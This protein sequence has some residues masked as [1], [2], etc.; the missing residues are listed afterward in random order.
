[1]KKKIVI[2]I[3]V[4]II[5]ALALMIGLK[6]EAQKPYSKPNIVSD[7]PDKKVE[8]PKTED[9]KEDKKEEEKKEE[10]PK[11]E[12][13]LP[14]KASI[15]D[16]KIS[17]DSSF[18]TEERE[19]IKAFL[20]T[21]F[22]RYYDIIA[23]LEYEDIS[24]MF[25]NRENAYIYKIALELLIE[26]RNQSMLDLKLS[27][28]KYE[29]KVQDY[30]K[31]DDS[32]S[33]KV[34]ENCSYNFD[35][36]K[37]FP[38][39]VYNIENRFT[40]VKEE[41]DYKISYF[42]KV[43]DF[44]V[45]ITDV[46]KSTEDYE[47]ALDKVKADYLKKFATEN[48]KIKTMYTNYL[49]GNYGTLKCDHGFDREKAYEYA[50]TW[51]GRRNTSKWHTYSANCVNF[52][53]QVMYAGGI[54]MDHYGSEQWKWYSTKKNTKNT[55]SGFVYSW[56]YVPSIVSYF[57]NNTGY[58]LCG[59][60]NDNLYLGDKGDIIVVG[61]T[62]PTRHVVSVVGQIKD[63]NGKV[64]DLLV[65]SNTVDLEYFPLSAYAYPYK[66]LMKVY[67]WND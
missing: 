35:S 49:N 17:F 47:A 36:T 23:K 51:V 33:F 21:F 43:Q 60:Y 14:T 42:K 31:T 58:G 3:L 13:K 62:G 41:N 15:T 50:I 67:G 26:N 18:P 2:S 56:T 10:S 46:Y 1:M 61:S 12:V 5:I 55:A 66:V 53:S 11:E 44:Y 7:K 9:K 25:Q 64:V 22:E 19:E 63:E 34:L 30:K 39:A 57:K 32:I 20:K 29:L 38:T 54:P 28:V 27:N 59:K 37:N 24:D 48:G 52:V 65:N 4:L 40:L 16:K 8:E 6:F 45:M